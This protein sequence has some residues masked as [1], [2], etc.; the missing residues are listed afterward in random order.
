M[1]DQ[2]STRLVVKTKKDPLGTV[3]NSTFGAIPS[4]DTHT[5][6]NTRKQSH[7]WIMMVAR[8]H[9]NGPVTEPELFLIAAQLRAQRV[10]SFGLG[11]VHTTL[12][13]PI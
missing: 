7:T 1:Q 4:F 8:S 13:G 5:H 6:T 3:S 12:Q 2:M 10:E 11:D 9:R